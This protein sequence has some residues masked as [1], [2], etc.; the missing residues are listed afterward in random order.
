MTERMSAAPSLATQSINTNTDQK[1]LQYHKL[2]FVYDQLVCLL[3]FVSIKGGV[4]CSG[5][6]GS[7]SR[8]RAFKAKPAAR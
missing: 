7:L 8:Y 5:S 6:Q 3:H 1:E 4:S 2:V